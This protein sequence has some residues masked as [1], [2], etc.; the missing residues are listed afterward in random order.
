MVGG[1]YMVSRE[2]VEAFKPKPT[3]RTRTRP[4]QWRTYRSGSS[5]RGMEIQVQV[6]AGQQEQLTQKLLAVREEQKYLFP[7]TMQRYV[8]A[9]ETQST[10]IRVLLIWKNT[11]LPDETT[12]DRELDAFKAEFVDLLDWDAAHYTALGAIIYT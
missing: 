1:I 7:G 8:V 10:A 6:R 11:E 5:V 3:G 4:T 12:L 9:D 2:A